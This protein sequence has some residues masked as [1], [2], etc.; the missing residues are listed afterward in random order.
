M[1]TIQLTSQLDYNQLE[2]YTVEMRIQ[3]NGTSPQLESKSVIQLN[4]LGANNHAPLFV[5]KNAQIEIPETSHK[6]NDKQLI[7]KFRAV[8]LDD[9]RNGQ[10]F[11]KLLNNPYSQRVDES[12][13][14]KLFASTFSLSRVSGELRLLRALDRDGID[15]DLLELTVMAFDNGKVKR[16]SNFTLSIRVVDLN[17]NRPEFSASRLNFSVYLE[18]EADAQ[19]WVIW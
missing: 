9:N 16:S 7:Y 17:E 6:A 3:D 14:K 2:G 1:Y 11:Y 8:D 19:R 15:G 10:V 12:E 18:P 5:N 13:A 4:V